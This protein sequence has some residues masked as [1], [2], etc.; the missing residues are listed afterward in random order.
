MFK[1]ILESMVRQAIEAARSKGLLVTEALPLV[2]IDA[3]AK[4]EFGESGFGD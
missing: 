1:E 2:E 4:E 3:P